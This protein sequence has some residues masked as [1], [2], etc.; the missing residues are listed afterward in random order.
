MLSEVHVPTIP[1]ST[2]VKRDEVASE[3]P[4]RPPA[5]RRLLIVDDESYPRRALA[6]YMRSRGYHV[7]EADSGEACLKELSE[8]A[9]SVVILDLVMPGMGGLET[10]R[11][12]RR[13]GNDVPVV[14]LTAI[15]DIDAAME[16]TRLGATEYI[17]KPYQPQLVVDAVDRC[18]AERMRRRAVLGEDRDASGAGYGELVGHSSAMQALFNRLRTLEGIAP[19]SVLVMGESGT[20]KDVVARTIHARGPRARSPFV[21]VDCTSIP[22]SLMESTLFGHERGAFTGAARQHAG[23]FEVAAGGVVFL[24]EIGEM[25]MASQA[26]LLR[27]LEN[28]RFKR[29][30]GTTDIHFDACVIA[31]TNRDL[32]AEVAAGR[33]REDLYYRLAIIPVEVPPLRERAEDVPL[34]VRHFAR[35]FGDQF[36]RKAVV[37]D[38]AMVAFCDYRWPGNVRELR[39]VLERLVIFNTG[40]SITPADLPPE[41]RF[42]RNTLSDASHQFVL[43]D[44]GVDLDQ[45]ERSLIEQALERTA[46]NQVQAAKLVGLTRFGIRSRMKKFGMLKSGD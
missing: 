43:P 26:K 9:P 3:N 13:S 33:F 14:I 27:T 38:D 31:A 35:K 17:T 45:V 10:L 41:I 6:R 40:N 44:E 4:A 36:N 34:L 46:G 18:L 15:H 19:P 25:A 39:N 8:Q 37:D 23:L 16:A 29:V 21:E 11:A 5:G 12:M 28:R 22:E 30:G 32:M 2:L 1:S 42:S 7:S 20:G 24:D